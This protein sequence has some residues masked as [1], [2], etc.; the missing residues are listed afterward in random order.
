VPGE[1]TV[2]TLDELLRTST[3]ER[4][5]RTALRALA[6]HESPRA[7][8]IVR[9]TIERQDASDKLR[10]YA[11]SAIDDDDASPEDAAFLRGLYTRVTSERLKKAVIRGV[12]SIDGAENSAWLMSLARN[13]SEPMEMRAEALARVGRSS[14]VTIGD[15]IGLY[16]ALPSREMRERLISLY[17]RRKEPEATD[18][19][20]AIAKTGTDPQLRRMAISA[21]TRKNDPRTTQLLLEIIEP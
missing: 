6:A 20:I 3:D 7:R 1:Q 4:V 12:G 21:L 19:L 17:S 15:L 18:K 2:N 16:D 9:A 11:L 10:E 13:N 8:Q 14:N 5:Q